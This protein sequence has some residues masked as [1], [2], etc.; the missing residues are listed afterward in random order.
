MEENDDKKTANGCDKK[1]GLTR[2]KWLIDI[3]K[4]AAV[5][6]VAGKSLP[7]EAEGIPATVAPKDIPEK[8]PPGLYSP[9]FHHLG[10]ALGNDSRFHAIPPGCEVDFIRLRTGP[11]EPQFFTQE[12]YKVIHKLTALILGEPEAAPQKNVQ[13]T[14]DNI[15]DEVA[16]WIDL[17]TYSFSGIREAAERLTP[18]QIALAEAYDGARLLH[19]IKTTDPPKTYRA[20]LTWIAE[21]SKRRQAPAFLGLSE[22]QQ[23]A[24]LDLISDDHGGENAETDG[25]RF[26]RQFKDDVISCFYTSRTGLKELDDKANRF[27]GESPGCPS[28]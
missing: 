24:I 2:R 16:E 22:K 6:G 27:Y 9:A 8:L 4:A 1:I 18:E 15:V 20:G 13:P 28:S 17:R 5:A 14:S 12:E 11:F 26:F 21:E 25:T 19:R 23:I 7:F 3:G 10:S